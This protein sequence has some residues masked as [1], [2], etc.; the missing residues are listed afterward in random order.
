VYS[1]CFVHAL[2]HLQKKTNIKRK[3]R[4]EDV[5]KYRVTALNS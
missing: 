5:G 1:G 2:H 3:N 4:R